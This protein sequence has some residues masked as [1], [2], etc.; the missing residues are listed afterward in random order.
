MISTLDYIPNADPNSD[1]EYDRRVA[2]I[3]MAKEASEIMESFNNLTHLSI[4]SNASRD[5]YEMRNCT[6]LQE[7]QFAALKGRVCCWKF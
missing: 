6:K 7:G 3:N 1:E 2:Y 5:P 4:T